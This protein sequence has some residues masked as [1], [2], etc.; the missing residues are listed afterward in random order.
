MYFK[1]KD[2]RERNNGFNLL[3]RLSLEGETVSSEFLLKCLSHPNQFIRA[4]TIRE[5]SD[6]KRHDLTWF[7]GLS[8][9]DRCHYVV[10]EAS[11]AL[12][13]INSDEALEILSNL[14][15]ENIVEKP[16]GIAHA[17]SQ[18]GKRG[19]EVLLKGIKNESPNIRYFSA[20]Y[21]GLTG[22]ESAKEILEE[23]MLNDIE[24]TSFGGLVSTAA[25]KGLKI[26]SKLHTKRST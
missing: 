7:F 16:N 17:I 21:L 19:Y 13:K 6:Y 15:F 23:I 5:I 12:A 9:N 4:E 25:K 26:L 14:L 22:V 24:K 18:F 10:E 8:L 20:K 2:K 3:E 1:P 11:Q